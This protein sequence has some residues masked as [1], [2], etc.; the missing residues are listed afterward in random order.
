MYCPHIRHFPHPWSQE[1]TIFAFPTEEAEVEDVLL[2][3]IKENPNPVEFPI[4]VIGAKP[5]T[6]AYLDDGTGP[7]PPPPPL[8]PGEK[9]GP[10]PVNKLLVDGIQFGRLLVNKKDTRSFIIDNPGVESVDRLIKG[11]HQ[12]SLLINIWFTFAPTYSTTSDLHP[13]LMAP[14][15]CFQ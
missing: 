10:P 6:L 13:P 7:P 15:A 9:P 1:L 8:A 3:K 14:Q 5:K 12:C 4:S 11:A 2:A